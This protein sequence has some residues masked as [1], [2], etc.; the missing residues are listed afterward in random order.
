MILKNHILN[1]I[2]FK[3]FEELKEKENYN[4]TNNEK[5]LKSNSHSIDIQ[6]TLDK[7]KELEEKKLNEFSKKLLNERNKNKNK[8]KNNDKDND[9]DSNT[10]TNTNM[11]IEN[12]Y[13]LDNENYKN[14]TKEEK[15]KLNLAKILY[16]QNKGKLFDNL[17]EEERKRLIGNDIYGIYSTNNTDGN[18][19]LGNNNNFNDKGIRIKNSKKLKKKKK[20]IDNEKKEI[21]DKINEY[22]EKME[23]KEITVFYIMIIILFYFSYSIINK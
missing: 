14:L 23:N 11:K 7:Y 21:K 18:Y 17:N 2:K 9:N 10:N 3:E 8:N 5:K 6:K 22:M 16:S 12:E 4:N 1:D 19:N 15:K 20:V 13:I